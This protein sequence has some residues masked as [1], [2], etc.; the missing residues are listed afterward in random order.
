ME[1]VLDVHTHSLASGHS[2]STIRE[3]A[4]A[5]AEKGLKVLGITEHAPKMPGSCHEFY[6]FNLKVVP[7]QMCGVQLLLGSEVN[8]IDYDGSVDLREDL[9]KAMDV[10]IASF[11]PP[12]LKIGTREENTQ[13]YIKAMQNPYVDIIGHPDDAR[14]PIDLEAVIAAAKENHKLIELNNSSLRE[15]GAREGAFENQIRILEL[16]RKYQ[17]GV[18]IGSDAHIDIEVGNHERTDRVLAA[19]DFPKE[20]LVNDSFEKLKPYLHKYKDLPFT[21]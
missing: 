4:Y 1:Y 6:F 15:N 13:A 12:C 19:V 21:F 20:L 17:T 11:H 10:V 9:L 18:I 5:A 2:Y 3:M 14:I 8:I 16:C 7:R